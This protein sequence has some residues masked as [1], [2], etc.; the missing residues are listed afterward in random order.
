MIINWI[1]TTRCGL[2]VALAVAGCASSYDG[3]RSGFLPASDYS[4]LKKGA[5]P[6]GGERYV[7][8]SGELAPYNYNLMIIERPQFYPEPR[9][10]K[11]VTTKTLEQV[12]SYL[13]ESMRTQ[14]GGRVQL[15][16]QAGA[17]VARLR[18]GITSVGEEG[19]G[20]EAML[21]KAFGGGTTGADGTQV[22]TIAMEVELT[23]SVSGEPLLLV[24][25]DGIGAD[26]QPNRQGQDIVTLEDLK[27][28]IDRWSSA[29]AADVTDYIQVKS[30]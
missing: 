24:V 9:P 11:H 1:Q 6:G 12:R 25:R 19:R 28:F 30:K 5:A 18:V 29:A 26:V 8:I 2:I 20:L 23:N 15:V 17:G 7:Y 22:S 27:P 10:S 4:M 14:L 16:D 13:Y 21:D 3:P